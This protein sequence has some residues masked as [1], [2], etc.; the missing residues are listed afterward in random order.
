[1]GPHVAPLGMR[2]YRYFVN[3]Q[4]NKAKFPSVSEVQRG[5]WAGQGQAG[6]GWRRRGG[7][8]VGTGVHRKLVRALA[9][10]LTCPTAC[11]PSCLLQAYDRN[12]LVAEHGSW[13]RDQPIGARVMRVLLSGAG[14]VAS[15]V[16]FLTG[17]QQLWVACRPAHFPLPHLCRATNCAR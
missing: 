14:K 16:P 3:A 9:K 8:H 11:V 15:Y 10:A 7:K 4:G 17:K 13:N 1:M 2:F 5:A 6:S 12:I